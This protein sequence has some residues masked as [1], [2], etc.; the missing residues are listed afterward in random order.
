VFFPN[1]TQIL[2]L[3]CLYIDKEFNTP[4]QQN[5]KLLEAIGS[6]AGNKIAALA[7]KAEFNECY[8]WENA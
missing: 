5:N 4:R 6:N 8:N 1:W 3:I 7:T 2:T